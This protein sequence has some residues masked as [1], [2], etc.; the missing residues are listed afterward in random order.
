MAETAHLDPSRSLHAP[1]GPKGEILVIFGIT[2]DLA[3]KMTLMSLYRLER[4]GALSTRIIGVGRSDWS[5]DDLKRHVREAVEAKVHEV[6]VKILAR[7]EDRLSYVQGDYGD[8]DT[9]TRLGKEMG[10]YDYAVFY[11]ETPPSLF[12]PVVQQLGNAGLTARAR[13]VL[14]K[15]FGDSLQSARELQRQLLEVLTEDQIYR[16]DHFL[17]KEPVMDISYLRFANSILEPIWKRNFVDSIQITMAENFGVEDRGSFYDKVGAVRDV[18]QNHLLQLLALTGMEPPS[19][20]AEPDPIRDRKLDFF[21][22]IHAADPGRYV[23][24]Q[25]D[26]YREID[27]VDPNSTTETFAAIRLEAQNWRW[28]GVPF[29]I[30]A[31]KALPTKLTEIRIVLESPP[32]LG[33]GDRPVPAAD[34]IIFRIDPQA[35]ACML[36]EAKQPGEEALRRVHLDLLFAQQVGEQPTPYERLLSDAVAGKPEL[37]SRMDIVEETWRIVQPLIDNPCAIET[38]PKGSWGPESAAHLT[39]G[40][41]GWRRPWLPSDEPY[42]PVGA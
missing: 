4:R 33:I 14:E 23:R 12:A 29:F 27:G 15:P 26:S 39:Q 7:L 11:L 35:G 16:I 41:G 1:P 19:G 9:Y 30:R 20:G 6:D 24:G 2:G 13:V 40:Y 38:Y 18:V 3:R 22:S 8:A 34:E 17:G 5:H 28:A 36:M 10:E 32:A 25:Y 37:F 42:G 31:G 21:R